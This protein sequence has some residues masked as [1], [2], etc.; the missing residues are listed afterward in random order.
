MYL[1]NSAVTNRLIGHL[2]S[3][4]KAGWE[5]EM[6]FISPSPQRDTV[7]ITI[8]HVTFKYCWKNSKIT[9]KY[10]KTA[11]GYWNAWKYV[12]SL[13]HNANILLLG[14][15]DFLPIFLYRKDLNIY[16]EIT[17]HPALGGWGNVFGQLS[18]SYYYS[19]C[20]K[21]KHLF[22]ISTA[23]RDCFIQHGIPSDRIS[24]INMTVDKTRF[25]DLTK[26]D[27]VEPYIAYCGTVSNTK[28]GVDELLKAFAITHQTHPKVKL[29]I[30][31]ATPSADDRA[32]NLKLIKS[33]GIQ[34]DVIFTGIVKADRMP[35]ILKNATVLALDRPNNLQAQNGFPTKLGEYLLTGNPVVITQVGDIP[36]FLKD[37][38]SAL[39]SQERNAIEFASK[40]N[41]ALDNPIQAEK[42]GTNG[43]QIALL[44]FDCITEGLKILKVIRA[45]MS[46]KARS[47]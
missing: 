9:N 14:L 38:E 25:E 17:E 2:Q 16:H 5:C 10:L 46:I 1:P 33:L 36:L 26:A 11:L 47:Q 13:P 31:G 45:D 20:A 8:P 40:M 44:H 35:Q 21:L 4:S 34:D 29:Y 27:G 30:I 39:L 37:G 3:F 43:K 22:V 15:K 41:W 19:Q 6:T 7:D 12:K 28:D 42:I 23:L 32:G 24:I 18:T